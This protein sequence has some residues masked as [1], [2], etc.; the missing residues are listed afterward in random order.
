MFFRA[1]ELQWIA[2]CRNAVMNEA[3]SEIMAQACT[4]HP[5]TVDYDKIM[6]GYVNLASE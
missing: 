6:I 2:E 3:I 5:I 4:D 1:D